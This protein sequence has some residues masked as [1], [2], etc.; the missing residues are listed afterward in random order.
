MYQQV[1]AAS[2]VEHSFDFYQPLLQ[3]AVAEL[4]RNPL[5]AQL[6]DEALLGV[7]MNYGTK[8][9]HWVMGWQGLARVHEH[10][11]EFNEARSALA[12][13]LTVSRQYVLSIDAPDAA[14]QMNDSYESLAEVES[15]AGQTGKALV[16]NLSAQHLGKYMRSD[17]YRKDQ[18]VSFE[19]IA[20]DKKVKDLLGKI[21]QY[22]REKN[23]AQ[24]DAALGAVVTGIAHANAAWSQMDATTS[25]AESR[26]VLTP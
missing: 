19:A 8:V 11:Q 24:M 22:R 7:R 17:A 3:Q 18:K 16:A 1:I 14:R 15:K 21:D 10:R 2:Q 13:A 23:Y 6:S 12:Q 5:T 4:R 25:L 20:A 26:G 9:R